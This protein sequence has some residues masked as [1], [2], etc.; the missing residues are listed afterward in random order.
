MDNIRSL[1]PVAL[2]KAAGVSATEAGAEV[3]ITKYF[4][5]PAKR[6]MLATLVAIPSGADTDETLAVKLQESTTT[7]DSDFTDISGAAFTGVAQEDA[8]A[9]ETIYFQTKATTKYI[10]S[11]ATLAG[12]TPA[13]SIVVEAFLLKRSA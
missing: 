2:H 7:V 8:A 11:H 3:D 13:F 6:E 5:S 10:R 12:T 1:H 4:V 9:L